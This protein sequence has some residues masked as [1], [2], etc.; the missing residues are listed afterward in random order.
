DLG[1]RAGAVVNAADGS[2]ILLA[3]L[4]IIMTSLYLWGLLER[5]DKSVFGMG[6]DSWWVLIAY[7]AGLTLLYFIT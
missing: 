1:Y 2:A 3:S 7:V 4:G 6:V 5:R